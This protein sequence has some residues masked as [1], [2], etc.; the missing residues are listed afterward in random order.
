MAA[1]RVAGKSGERFKS[2]WNPAPAAGRK[3]NPVDT[4]DGTLSAQRPR[5]T[6]SALPRSW[7]VKAFTSRTLLHHSSRRWFSRGVG[8]LADADL[9]ASF[10]GKSGSY[11]I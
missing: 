11:K 5:P 9:I 3:R 8:P 10:V 7:L 2:G 4:S 1:R 6:G